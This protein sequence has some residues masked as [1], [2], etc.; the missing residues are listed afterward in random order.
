MNFRTTLLSTLLC[1]LPLSAQTQ[2]LRG[3][4]DTIQGTNRFQLDCTNLEI[5][6]NTVNLQALHDASRQQDIDYEMQVRPALVAGRSVLEVLS[7]TAIPEQFQM[8]NLR[9]GRAETWE[10]FAPAGSEV[11]ALVGLPANA[12]YL[13]LGDAGTWLIGA[14]TPFLQGVVGP[15]GVLQVRVTMPTVPALVGTVFNAQAVIRTGGVLSI[16]APDCK[17]VRS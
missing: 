14:A 2:L 11:W 15:T 1:A 5:V 6:S 16:T 4:V 12:S 3:D 13:P 7:A 8:G 17:E 10:F 9:F